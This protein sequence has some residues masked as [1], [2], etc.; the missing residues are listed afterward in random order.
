MCFRWG[1]AFAILLEY[2]LVVLQ[3]LVEGSQVSQLHDQHEV[4]CLADPDHP[5]DVRVVQ[6][7][8]DVSF[9]QHFVAHRLVV[10]VVLQDF[11]GNRLLDPYTQQGVGGGGML[12]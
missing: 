8:H 2:T 4:L 7:L 12:V 3:E 10:V 11:D 9:P 5:D 6:L 1:D